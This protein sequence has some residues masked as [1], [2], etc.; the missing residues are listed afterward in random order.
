[1]RTT[2]VARQAV[3]SDLVTRDTDSKHMAMAND[4]DALLK[5]VISTF[6]LPESNAIDWVTALKSSLITTADVLQPWRT[7]ALY[8]TCKSVECTSCTDLV[9][10][11]PSARS[12]LIVLSTRRS[13]AVQVRKPRVDPSSC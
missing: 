11:W 6:N 5:T 10:R 4:L 8:R 12:A 2:R 9:P 13:G 1:M 7:Q 3:T